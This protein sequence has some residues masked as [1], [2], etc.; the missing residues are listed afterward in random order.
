MNLFF[1]TAVFSSLVLSLERVEGFKHFSELFYFH[2]VVSFHLDRLFFAWL[3]NLLLF[4]L[5]VPLGYLGHLSLNQANMLGQLFDFFGHIWLDCSFDW[6]FWQLSSMT[7][8]LELWWTRKRLRW[9]QLSWR[10]PILQGLA[11]EILIGR[12]IRLLVLR[13]KPLNLDRQ[14][15]LQLISIQFPQSVLSH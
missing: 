6:L 8:S 9:R 13:L 12:W 5:L 1:I 4:K 2:L 10:R 15:L 11:L 3:L 14:M 7:F